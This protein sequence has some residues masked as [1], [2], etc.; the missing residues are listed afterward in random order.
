MHDGCVPGYICDSS[1]GQCVMT[2]AGE[3]DT[4]ANCEATCS[5]NPPPDD[6]YTCDV[7]T[8]TCVL[9]TTGTSATSC[10]DACADETPSQ[11]VGLWRGLSV[12]TGF[13]KV[14]CAERRAANARAA[15]QLHLAKGFLF[16]GA[17]P[18]LLL[19][20]PGRRST[21]STLRSRR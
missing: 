5:E 17:I 2:D 12:N 18:L 7:E 19:Y 4:Q 8:F 10:S 20:H 13:D 16:S 3:G 21:C 14:T 15:P 1:S 6:Q 9:D 11:I